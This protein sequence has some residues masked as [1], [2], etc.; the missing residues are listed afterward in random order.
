M[1][2]HKLFLCAGQIEELN[3]VGKILSPDQLRRK[4]RC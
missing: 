4:R 2:C 1:T 3:L